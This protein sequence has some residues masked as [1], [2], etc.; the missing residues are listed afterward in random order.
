MFGGS[1]SS[2]HAKKVCKVRGGLQWEGRAARG[3]AG[4]KGRGGLQGEGWAA[5]RGAGCK[6]R[7]GLICCSSSK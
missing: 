3:G 6:A 5:R 1:L 7:G 4:C 2:M